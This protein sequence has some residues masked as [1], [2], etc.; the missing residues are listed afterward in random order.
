LKKT[1][2]ERMRRRAQGRPQWVRIWCSVFFVGVVLQFCPPVFAAEPAHVDTVSSPTSDV[3]SDSHFHAVDTHSSEADCC[4]IDPAHTLREAASVA[5]ASD[6]D[7]RIPPAVATEHD[8][9]FWS[10]TPDTT[11]LPGSTLE[12]IAGRG[13]ALYLTTRRLRI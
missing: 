9:I 12:H 11:T 3:E 6:T 4:H 1:L 13:P 8:E 10:S 7:L 5:I 2:L